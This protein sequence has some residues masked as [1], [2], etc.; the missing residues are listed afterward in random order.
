MHSTDPPRRL[1]RAALAC[2][3]AAMLAGCASDPRSGSGLEWVEGQ[4]AERQR[5]EAMGFPQFTGAN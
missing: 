5:L 3:L 2:I 1:L 4:A